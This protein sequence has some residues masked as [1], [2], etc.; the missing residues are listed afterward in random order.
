MLCWLTG[1]N[2]KAEEKH[3]LLAFIVILIILE[4]SQ[5]LFSRTYSVL[6]SYPL[7]PGWNERCNHT[8]PATDL[9]PMLYSQTDSNFMI[10]CV[11]MAPLPQEKSGEET[12]VN[13]CC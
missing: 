9:C 8:L 7:C 6:T 13:R 4:K 5:T 10:A 3:I 1:E 11:Q 12:S 2:L